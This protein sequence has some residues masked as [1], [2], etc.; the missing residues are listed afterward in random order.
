MPGGAGT[1]R[2][3]R[4]LHR[5]HAIAPLLLTKERFVDLVDGSAGIATTYSVSGLVSSRDF[6]DRPASMED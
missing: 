2:A 5:T 6:L 4:S 1:Q 3:L